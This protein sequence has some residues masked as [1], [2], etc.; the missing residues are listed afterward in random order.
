MRERRPDLI[1]QNRGNPPR[2][3]FCRR[4]IIHALRDVGCTHRDEVSLSMIEARF[5]K[6]VANTSHLAGWNELS[7][8]DRETAV[9]RFRVV[10]HPENEE[11]SNQ[12]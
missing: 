5:V 2:A 3:S 11:I 10:C 4:P 6:D 8:L 12:M 9:Y 7:S 1:R